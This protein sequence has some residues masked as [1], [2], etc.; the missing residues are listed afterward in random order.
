METDCSD[1]EKLT[2]Y[3]GSS[4]YPAGIERGAPSEHLSHSMSDSHHSYN[5]TTIGV[6]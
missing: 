2:V 4:Q 1:V 6:K 5:Y 3:L